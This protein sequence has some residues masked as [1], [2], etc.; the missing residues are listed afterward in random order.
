LDGRRLAFNVVTSNRFDIEVISADGQ[1][2]RSIIAT[3]ASEERP[4]WSADGQ[5]LTYYSNDG[6]SW[7]VYT[8]L[9]ATG[10][11]RSLT[12]SP[13]FDGQPAWRPTPR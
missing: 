1:D 12:D 9:V 13:G 7:E 6:G 5:Q 11:A 3:D 4:R 10:A 2:R 8:V